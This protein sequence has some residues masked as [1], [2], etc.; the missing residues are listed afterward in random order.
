MQINCYDSEDPKKVAQTLKVFLQVNFLRATNV[1]ECNYYI[2]NW[3]F[4][5][6]IQ[7]IGIQLGFSIFAASMVLLNNSVDFF[8]KTIS[9]SRDTANFIS[10]GLNVIGLVFL[11]LGYCHGSIE[12]IKYMQQML[13]L[14]LLLRPFVFIC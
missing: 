1:C 13:V 14:Q 10:G 4:G 8:F 11:A 6:V 9:L 7:I 5:A 12:R 3:I 2:I